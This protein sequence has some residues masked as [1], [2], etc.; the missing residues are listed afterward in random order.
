MKGLVRPLPPRGLTATVWCC[1]P[2]MVL[3]CASSFG[4]GISHTVV[5]GDTLS[6]IADHYLGDSGKW[7]RLRQA[8]PGVRERALPPG[9][10]IAVPA[11]A[12]GGGA[13]V[14][15]V[16]GRAF[17]TRL[18]SARLLAKDMEVLE[19]DLLTVEEGGYVTLKWP[20]GV[21]TH[22]LPGSSIRLARSTAGA[23]EGGPSRAIHLLRG[24]VES[25]VP[26]RDS[27]KNYMIRTRWGVAGVR[28]TQFGVRLTQSG[29]MVTEVV[30]GAVELAGADYR[31]VQLPAGTGA[32]VDQ[33]HRQPKA[34]PML[35]APAMAEERV[36]A[37]DSE[38]RSAPVPGAVAYEFQLSAAAA[39][40]IPLLRTRSSAPALGLGQVK[41]GRY[42]V[43]VRA[44]AD[45]G[46]P[47]LPGAGT[48]EVLSLASPF[49]SEPVS[50]VVLPADAGVRLLCSDVPNASR[51]EFQV[52]ASDRQGQEVHRAASDAGCAVELP[53]LATGN[54][55]WTVNAARMLPGGHLLRGV[56]SQ[57]GRFSIV[58][59]PAAPATR[60][61]AG[62]GLRLMW[63]GVPD[64]TY[65]V[66]VARDLE[67][68]S[69]VWEGTVDVPQA[70][71]DVPAGRAYF[72]RI[73]TLGGSGVASG[74]SQPRIVR[75]PL[76]LSTSE[77]GP[78]R[79]SDGTVVEPQ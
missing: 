1:M 57:A 4:Q 35:P 26:K 36:L 45:D 31:A 44:V 25:Q 54:Y 71:I 40:D 22:L 77:G 15:H 17:L 7:V 78:V 27:G 32:V 62:N 20:E 39:P 18:G 6:G 56:S 19:T 23:G 55:E 79:A 2:G 47:G 13:N 16:S 72:V 63:D 51:Y 59:R 58:P 49:L 46:I 21:I 30:E 74:F 65:L 50:G 37:S 68:G 70:A 8:N 33:A 60:V 43:T 28:G 3:F 73:K 75:G 67:F 29:A 42:R 61:D 10:Q 24:T 38:F 12:P 66:Q 48:L 14:L 41:D 76:R 9:L 11:P 52:R 34:S 64:A 53:V 5:P 69:L